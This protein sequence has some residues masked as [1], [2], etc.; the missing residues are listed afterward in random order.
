MSKELD[1]VLQHIAFNVLV[2]SGLYTGNIAMGLREW[3]ETRDVVNAMYR[4]SEFHTY[5]NDMAFL[6]DIIFTAYPNINTMNDSVQ[7]SSKS[8][9]F[10]T[11]SLAREGLRSVAIPYVKTVAYKREYPVAAPW[12]EP[13]NSPKQLW[14]GIG[15]EPVFAI[16]N[17]SP[18]SIENRYNSSVYP[19]EHTLLYDRVRML[20]FDGD[21]TDRGEKDIVDL[22]LGERVRIAPYRIAKFNYE[23]SGSVEELLED[24]ISRGWLTILEYGDGRAKTLLPEL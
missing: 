11:W 16:A 15:E 2:Q 22:A 21:L 17:D 18:L 10:Q 5:T 13:R 14:F 1:G 20:T 7:S 4:W 8:W 19:N 6:V 9:R 12:E 24:L 23:D 3:L